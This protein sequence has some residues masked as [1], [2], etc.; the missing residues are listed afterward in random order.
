MPPDAFDSSHRRNVAVGRSTCNSPSSQTVRTGSEAT[1]SGTREAPEAWISR[2]RANRRL[3][4]AAD[5][6]SP[7]FPW[8]RL[9]LAKLSDLWPRP[10]PPA[11]RPTCPNASP[12]PHTLC[13]PPIV[14][15]QP[16]HLPLW[17]SCGTRRCTSPP[18]AALSESVLTSSAATAGSRRPSHFGFYL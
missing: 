12:L 13:V 15:G 2:G 14:A 10:P 6:S 1:R 9:P 18:N 16:P 3:A 7:D 8:A 5:P 4:R 11:A 17:S